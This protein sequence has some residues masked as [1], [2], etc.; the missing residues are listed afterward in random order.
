MHAT[1][2][3]TSKER[4]G[5]QYVSIPFTIVFCCNNEEIFVD[6]ANGLIAFVVYFR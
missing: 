2:S 6:I 1:C 3:H 5:G 4:C